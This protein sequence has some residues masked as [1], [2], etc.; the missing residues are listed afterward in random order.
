MTDAP[1]WRS[2]AE[3]STP[4]LTDTRLQVHHAAQAMAAFGQT[5]LQARDDDSHRSMTWDS[6][7]ERFRSE[8]ADDGTRVELSFRPLALH[9]VPGSGTPT[10]L[11]LMGTTMKTMKAWL[12]RAIPDATGWP[13]QPVSWPDYDMPD[14]AVLHGRPFEPLPRAQHALVAWYTNADALLRELVS[15]EESASPL[16]VWPHHF[17]IASLVT[18]ASEGSD[19]PSTVGVGL[20]PGDGSY[21][22][23]YFYVLPWPKPE[24]ETLPDFEGP[25]HWH[26]DGWVGLVLPTSALAGTDQAKRSAA[27]AFLTG[28]FDAAQGVLG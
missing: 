26:T 4:R 16:R 18:I 28:G 6:A 7:A 15:T 27:R 19:T 14:H 9:V 25:G 23:P 10:S 24:V 5:F 21:A 2:P 20:S 12:E 3:V 17:D 1:D 13:A 11:R 22:D 8:P